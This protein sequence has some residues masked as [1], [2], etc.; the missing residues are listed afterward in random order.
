MKKCSAG[1]RLKEKVP[2]RLQFIEDALDATYLV[3]YNAFSS[4]N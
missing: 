3:K 2:C 1:C 4:F